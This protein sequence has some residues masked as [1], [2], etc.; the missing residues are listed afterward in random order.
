MHG[1]TD[2][3]YDNSHRAFLQAFMSRSTMT[4]EEA[5]PI[6]A[7]VFSIRGA[8]ISSLFPQFFFAIDYQL[9]FLIYYVQANRNAVTLNTDKRETQ[10]EDITHN[11]LNNYISAVNTAISPFDLEIRSTLHQANQTRVYSL[12]NITS[13]PLMQLATT[14]TADEIA[15]VK[16]LLDAMF[17]KNNTT[18]EEAMVVSSMLAVQLA[19]PNASNSNNNRRQSQAAGTQT[20]SQGGTAQP[21]SMKE[22]EEMLSRLVSE[23]W[24]EKSRK[25]FYGLTPRALMEL[26]VW[27][28][29]TYN[30]DEDDDG[31][32]YRNDKIKFCAACKEIITIVCVSC[33]LVIVHHR[34]LR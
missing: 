8:L 9:C 12:I 3:N 16:R 21:L 29:E 22:A 24:L 32:G 34:C 26:R 33:I 15:Y 25:G 4:F 17:E 11:D 1:H 27:L 28:V 7:H 31:G 2:N 10:V 13:D 18:R 14:Y 23:G 20:Q 5:K 19:R 6:L 30:D